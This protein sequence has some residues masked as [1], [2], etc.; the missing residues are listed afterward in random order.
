MPKHHIMEAYMGCGGTIQYILNLSTSRK[1]V[2]NF[3]ARSFH[4]WRK[5]LLPHETVGPQSR[6]ERDVEDRPKIEARSYLIYFAG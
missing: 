6:F 4:P 2:V 1:L 3:R 5:I